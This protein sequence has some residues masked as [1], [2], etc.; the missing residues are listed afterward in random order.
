VIQHLALVS[1][2]AFLCFEALDYAIYD[3]PCLEDDTLAF[4]SI[5][6]LKYNEKHV[7]FEPF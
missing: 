5:K 7:T 6:V 4:G 1:L 2:D 3:I